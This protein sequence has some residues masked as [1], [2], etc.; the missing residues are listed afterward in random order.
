MLFAQG[1]KI[2]VQDGLDTRKAAVVGVS[3]WLGV[4]FQ[5]D[6]I[7]AD[8]LGGTLETLLGNGLTTGA[9]P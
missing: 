4:G 3:F 1:M 7:F 2:V 5:N 8:I 6:L 9:L